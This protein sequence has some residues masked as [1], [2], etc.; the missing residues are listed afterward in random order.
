MTWVRYVLLWTAL[1]PAGTSLNFF[2]FWPWY[3]F[4]RTRRTL[5]LAMFGAF[6]VLGA[7][8]ALALRQWTFVRW[9]L[10][11]AAQVG[12]WALFAA[13]FVL[14]SVADRQIGWRVRSFVPHF[15]AHER[16][17]LITTGAYGVVR[18]PIYAACTYIQLAAFLITGY[19]SALVA[20]AVFG[21]GALW[22]TRREEERTTA[23]LADPDEYARYRERVPA[24]VP[25]LR[26]R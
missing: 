3:E 11:L 6:T 18:H 26:R 7:A 16:I 9:H 5:W 25:W 14:A 4:W 15:E 10:P 22:Y 2:A 17:G 23:L 13:A 8:A 12:G 24:L 21:G 20:M 1:L 19:P